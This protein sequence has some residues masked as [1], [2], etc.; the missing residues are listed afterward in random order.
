M[1]NALKMTVSIAFLSAGMVSA[2]LLSETTPA[3]ANTYVGTSQGVYLFKTASSGALTLVKGS[4]FKTRGFAVGSNG[5]NFISVSATALYSYQVESD[6][7][8]GKQVSEL[9]T[10]SNKGTSCTGGSGGYMTAE[11]D[12]TGKNVYVLYED[13]SGPGGSQCT[14]ILTFDIAAKT[15]ALSYKSSLAVGGNNGYLLGLPSLTANNTFGYTTNAFGCCG[16]STEWSGF[17]RESNGELENIEFTSDDPHGGYVPFFATAG[18]GDYV[19]AIVAT[20]PGPDEYGPE[21]LASYT[22]NSKGDIASTNIASKMPTIAGNQASLLSIS[23]SGKLIAVAGFS[24]GLQIF[25]FN[26]AQPVTSFSAELDTKSGFDSVC[27]DN[28]NHL[29]ALSFASGKTPAQLFVYDV[30]PTSIKE[31]PGSPYKVNASPQAL[32]VV[33]IG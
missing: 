19:A 1:I 3:V 15:G 14:A 21:K 31:A 7:A 25:H 29:Y 18:Y 24:S 9:N 12:K 13:P 28:D 33:P 23:P 5:T 17:K 20:N 16:E 26:G 6:G 8:I 11:L 30:T 32:A 10:K 4:P 2:Q 27:W 22:V